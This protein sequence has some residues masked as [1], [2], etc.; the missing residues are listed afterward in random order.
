MD[1]LNDTVSLLSSYIFTPTLLKQYQS[2]SNKY[3]NSSSSIRYIDSLNETQAIQDF[4]S[5]STILMPS[6]QTVLL[7]Q[8]KRL[9]VH[10]VTN[11]MAESSRSYQISSSDKDTIFSTVISLL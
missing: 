6:L 5:Q 10:V 2:T 11:D 4:Y 8:Y 1:T 9:M 3:T 7:T